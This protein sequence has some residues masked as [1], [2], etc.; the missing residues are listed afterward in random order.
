[1]DDTDKEQYSVMEKQLKQMCDDY[2]KN[3]C[4]AIEMDMLKKEDPEQH[5]SIILITN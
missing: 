2:K 1:M 4:E 3:F 5:V